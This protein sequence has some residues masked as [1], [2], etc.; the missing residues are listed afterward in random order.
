[1]IFLMAL[2]DIYTGK[3]KFTEE[4]ID[5]IDLEAPDL[6]PNCVATILHQSRLSWRGRLQPISLVS[7]TR[8]N[9]APGGT[10]PA[11]ADRTASTSSAVAGIE[12]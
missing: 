5:E 2:Q 10:I 6:I 12:K 7:H 11:L 9:P 1:M 8:R 3:S 4:E